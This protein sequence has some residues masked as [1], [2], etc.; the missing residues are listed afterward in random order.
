MTYTEVKNKIDELILKAESK[1]KLSSEQL[2]KLHNKFRLEWN[3]NSNS[4]EGNTLTVAE[5]RSVMIGNIDVRHKPIKDILEVKGHDEVISSILKLGKA[6]IRLSEKR[7]KEIHQAI[8]YEE[9][10]NKREQIGKWKT[11]AN[12]IINH[13]GEKYLFVL[14][15]DVSQRI[16]ELLNQTNASIDRIQRKTKDAPHPI[17]VA[18]N[19]HI[20]YL[21][22]H[23][24]YDGNGRTARVLSNLI[25][26]AL[27]YPPLWINDQERD[28]YYRYVADI[29]C[30]G[31]RREELFSFLGE[32]ILRSQGMVYDV[33]EGKSIEEVEDIDKEIE[34]LKRE[35]KA[36]ENLAKKVPN[37]EKLIEQNYIES[38][39]P[40]F[41]TI[42]SEIKKFDDLFGAIDTT[43]FY[44]FDSDSAYDNV[45]LSLDLREVYR[46]IEWH[47]DISSVIFIILFQ[48]LRLVDDLPSFEV[49]I[50]C[51]YH[52]SGYSIKLNDISLLERNYTHILQEEEI[53][54]LCKEIN[55]HILKEISILKQ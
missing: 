42:G 10:P 31:G 4:M 18:L 3:Y 22:I 34:L 25:L 39:E 30:Y 24:F 43:Y 5:T 13:K 1:G 7:I 20:E 41:R 16:H 11:D 49:E 44:E 32:L 21:N 12:E 6:E 35:L 40:L 33:L 45:H 17:D 37:K 26:V 50:I 38:I 14:P 8:M 36:K 53:L 19:F 15:E 52:Q 51:D 29:Q 55:T 23:P 48:E 54:D 9:D 2:N 28:I 27:G 47:R 46:K